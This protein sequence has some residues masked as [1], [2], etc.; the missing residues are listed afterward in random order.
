MII[1]LKANLL[2]KNLLYLFL[3]KAGKLE[4]IQTGTV[5]SVTIIT[6]SW[7]NYSKTFTQSVRRTRKS[8][9]KSLHTNQIIMLNF[10]SQKINSVHKRHLRNNCCWSNWTDWWI[11]KIFW[12]K[13]SPR[14]ISSNKLNL[15]RLKKCLINRSIITECWERY[16]R[17]MKKMPFKVTTVTKDL[18]HWILPSE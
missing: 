8:T 16:G 11:N 17:N 15:S 12:T 13:N 5:R 3:C 18:I 14:S 9:K 2:F 10:I 6:P 1:I 4:S 7:P